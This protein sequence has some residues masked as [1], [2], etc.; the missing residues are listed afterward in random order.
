MVCQD[1][2]RVPII[3]GCACVALLP[4]LPIEVARII[5]G[6][7]LAQT[8]D[9]VAKAVLCGTPAVLLRQFLL[10][11]DSGFWLAPG[12][13]KLKC[14][15]RP[16]PKPL[17]TN[18]RGQVIVAEELEPNSMDVLGGASQEDDGFPH[19]GEAPDENMEEQD[20]MEPVPEP[21]SSQPRTAAKSKP[22]A[23][24]AS[25]PAVVEAVASQEHAEEQQEA[26]E[27]PGV[28]DV[29]VEDAAFE[30]LKQ[31]RLWPGAATSEA[32]FQKMFSSLSDVNQVF[33]PKPSRTGR[34]FGYHSA[35]GQKVDRCSARALGTGCAGL[36]CPR[37]GRCARI[38]A[39][40]TSRHIRP[41]ARTH[42]LD[43]RGWAD[44]S[45]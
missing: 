4:A 6:H 22:R 3:V 16:Q 40:A 7:N 24:S 34:Q 29:P 33:Q 14:L 35:K 36:P 9:S 20:A 41:G 8:E 15:A 18:E 42:L 43:C 27:E 11:D 37:A 17:R 26:K 28:D 32:D 45:L 30:K 25:Q 13:E 44:T 10:I 1:R 23:P 31:R 2:Q 19:C 21:A 39:F 38:W 5:D 12:P